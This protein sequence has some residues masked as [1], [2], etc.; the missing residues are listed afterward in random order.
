M[1]R[2]H[3]IV[4]VPGEDST[5]REYTF[6]RPSHLV[7]GRAPDCDI[8]V[9]P[10]TIFT[11][12]SR[13]HCEFEIDPPQVRLRDLGSRNGTYINGT[14]IGHRSNT[15]SASDVGEDTGTDYEL[16]DR[17][18]VQV[19]FVTIRV[20]MEEVEEGLPAMGIIEGSSPEPVP[21]Q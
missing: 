6:T 16:H 11:N 2:V 3:V 20:E 13:H 1:K 17:D 21:E 10:E 4:N 18:E 12:I 9:P 8:R 19:G 7:L 15:I 5:T 14:L